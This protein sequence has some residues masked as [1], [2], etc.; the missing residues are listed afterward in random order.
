MFF[1]KKI[2]RFEIKI[3][4]SNKNAFYIIV[5]NRNKFSNNLNTSII[6]IHLFHISSFA[7]SMSCIVQHFI[8]HIHIN[9]TLQKSLETSFQIN[10]HIGLERAN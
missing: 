4:K 7:Y 3:M 8:D 10:K 9:C 1:F 2:P 6:S 5:Y